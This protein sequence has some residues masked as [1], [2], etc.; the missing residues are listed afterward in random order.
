MRKP[1][2]SSSG[3]TL[4]ELTVVLIIVSLLLG[5]LLLPLSAQQDIRQQAEAEKQLAEARD[6][7]VGFAQING[8][9]PCPASNAVGNGKEDCAGAVFGF[10]PWGEI[11]VRPTDP[12]GHLIRYRVSTAFKTTVPPVDTSTLAE[13]KIQ[14]R[15]GT[16]LIDL[17]NDAPRD[18]AFVIVSHGKNGYYGTNNDGS[19]GPADPGG[20]NNPDEDGNATALVSAG[21]TVFISR[22]PT[23][24]DAPTIGGFDDL[25][26]WMPR[27][28]LIN[29]L[30]AAGKI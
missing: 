17:T 2:P 6:A 21:S 22:T 26:V 28:L 15:Q 10:L 27:T 24:E 14:T 9:L 25:V 4:V 30:V 16:A 20:I 3:F 5:G 12:W 29:R 19:A 1:F 18:V 11:G 13:L 7:L 8:R 23:P